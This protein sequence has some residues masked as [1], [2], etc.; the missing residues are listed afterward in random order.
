MKIRASWS[1]LNLWQQGRIDDALLG[2]FHVPRPTPTNYINGK[3]WDEYATNY[4]NKHG[5]LPPEWG[6]DAL[7]GPITQLKMR[8]DYNELAD[9]VGVFDVLSV[10]LDE[11]Y[12]LK[13][14]HSM[15]ARAYAGTMQVPLYLLLGGP[16]I[17]KATIIR[18]NPK[19]DKQDRAIIYPTKRVLEKANNYLQTLIPEIYEYF[20]SHNLLGI[21]D[22]EFVSK[23]T[24]RL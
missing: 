9:L 19:T 3:L 7:K 18:Y 13:S 24:K 1:F 17:R 12:E 2:Y 21:T 8:M 11:L 20:I 14:G 5:K 16:L 23:L 22:Q 15:S 10:G 4:I 6:G